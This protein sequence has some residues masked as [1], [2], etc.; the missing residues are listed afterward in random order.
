MTGEEPHAGRHEVPAELREPEEPASDE[1]PIAAAAADQPEAP[2]APAA[3][4]RA[5][6]TPPT[7]APEAESP[8]KTDPATRVQQSAP[9]FTPSSAASGERPTEVRRPPATD[10]GSLTPIPPGPVA[11]AG[12]YGDD[13][14]EIKVPK[15]WLRFLSASVVI[16]AA[17]AAAVAVTGLLFI[18]DIAKSIQPLPGVQDQLT[19]VESDQP[20]TVLIIGSDRRADQPASDARSD[21]TMLLRIDPQLGLLS[22]FSLPRDLEVPIPGYSDAAKL[23]EAYTVGGAE[24]TLETVKDYTGL[25]INHVV[26]INFAGFAD[27]VNAIDCV[28]IDVDRDYEHSKLGLSDLDSYSEIDINAGYQRLCGLKALQYV[29]YRHTDT[30]IV[31]AARQQDFLREARQKVNPREL[32]PAPI[33]G[34]DTGNQLIDIFT[35][36]TRS[37]IDSAD[38]ILG[39]L[40][41]FIAVRSTPVNQVKFEGDLG[42]ATNTNV[43]TTPKQLQKA[44][45]K[46]LYGPEQAPVEE[47]TS[48]S[49][50]KPDSGGGSKGGKSD[51]GKDKKPADPL[52]DA[53]V[54]PVDQL[55]DPDRVRE[56][57]QQERAPARLP[58]LLADRRRARL[59]LRHRVAHLR[60]RERGQQEGRRLQDGDR[61]RARRRPARVLRRHGHD[62]G[63]SADPPRPLRDPDGGW[64][65]VR[66]RLGRLL[67]ALLRR[68][69]A[70]AGRLAGGRQLVLG[71]Q[72]AEPLA[73]RGPDAGDRDHDAPAS[74]SRLPRGLWIRFAIASAV[75]VTT[76]A[77]A[78]ASAGLI[79]FNDV[80]GKIVDI[81]NLD[82]P[83]PEEGDPYTILMLGSDQRSEAAPDDQRSDTTMLLRLDPDGGVISLLSLPRDLSVEIPG[84]GTDKLNAAYSAGGPKLTL[85]T[86]KQLT[87]LQINDVIDVDFQGFADAVNAVECVYIDVDQDY[88]IPE[89]TGVSAIDVNA[90]YQR[91]C[92]LKALQYVRYRHTDNDIVRAAR[93]QSFLREARQRID[94]GQILLG[95][96]RQR[97]AATPSSTT[98]ARRSRTGARSATSPPRCST[99]AAPPS[100][101]SRSPATS[102]RSTSTRPRPRSTVPSPSS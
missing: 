28:Y 86:V 76:V 60:V 4:P 87:G 5:D 37:D 29:R 53:N 54:I 19:A 11:V 32:I 1:L 50:S 12:G 52:A 59:D 73:Q 94:V 41:S 62:L 84:Y 55:A 90:G 79:F 92:G 31:R 23:N 91:L 97:P 74:T 101:R 64:G 85:R 71:Q 45:D 9:L 63:R 100:T 70:A 69:P 66:G 75:I 96:R 18:S 44:L 34:G 98:R 33:I 81:P 22:L 65:R 20:Q 68:R 39:I 83:P 42:D 89:G 2:A 82:P 43:T 77:A 56:R 80:A 58:G 13:E 3:K 78:T 17:T 24:K 99:C 16:V 30:D 49:G 21:T 61:V 27:A 36:Y 7:G 93:Q 35:K 14:L 88:Y 15:L 8:P 46:F 48:D 47:P 40:K 72:H 10:S 67:H 26:E 25:K 95:G 102:A 6:Q 38:Q 57:R 51:G